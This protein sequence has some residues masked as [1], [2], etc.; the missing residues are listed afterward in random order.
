M[1]SQKIPATLFTGFFGVGKTTAIRSLLSRKSKKEKWAILVNEFGEVAVDQTALGEDN[2]DNI[3]LPPLDDD[4]AA[5]SRA[6]CPGSHR[7]RRR[8]VL[9]D[10]VCLLVA[11]S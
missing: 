5:F 2:E 11:R 7:V 10:R 6:R 3:P 4:R 8:T 9:C 1:I